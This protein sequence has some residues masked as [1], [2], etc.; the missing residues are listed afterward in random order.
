MSAADRMPIRTPNGVRSVPR[1]VA[2]GLIS[3][4]RAKAATKGA[5]A[6]NIPA[7]PELI[8]SVITHAERIETSFRDDGSTGIEVTISDPDGVRA[9]A[10]TVGAAT[11]EELEAWFDGQAADMPDGTPEP[12]LSEPRG[13]ASREVW[14]EYA[15][16]RGVHVTDGMSRNKIRDAA[17][18]AQSVDSLPQPAHEGGRL[19][20]PEDEP[21]TES[22]VTDDTPGAQ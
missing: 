4:G 3:A 21:V 22:A 12:P 14:A 15:A 13:N 5:E 19:E 11:G 2:L 6:Q 7:T 10:E 8:H 17:R 16:S 18:A 9:V 1:R 20:T